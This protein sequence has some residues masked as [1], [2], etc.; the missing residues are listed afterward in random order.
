[1]LGQRPAGLSCWLHGLYCHRGSCYPLRIPENSELAVV[2]AVV[3]SD[4]D[5]GANGEITYSITGQS[6]SRRL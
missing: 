2:H 1:M 6:S 3:A 5:I 4:N